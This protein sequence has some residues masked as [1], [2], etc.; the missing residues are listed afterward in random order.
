MAVFVLIP[1]P[2]QSAANGQTRVEVEGETVKEA[3]RSLI[4]LYPS[5][6]K[7]LL[8]DAG[9]IRAFV[10]VFVNEEDVRGLRGENTPLKAG[11]ELILI[12]AVAGG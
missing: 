6:K 4:Q 3:L 9:T 10:N 12:P 1:T 7:S 2:L 11:D 5:L 8:T